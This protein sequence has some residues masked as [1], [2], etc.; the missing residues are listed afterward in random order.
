MSNLFGSLT[1]TNALH[2]GGRTFET[3]MRYS[4]WILNSS[5]LDFQHLLKN[6]YIDGTSV[7][8]I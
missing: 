2:T 3:R 1:K 6:I 4:S 8:T 5:W 7:F